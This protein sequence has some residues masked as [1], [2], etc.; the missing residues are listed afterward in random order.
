MT[1]DMVRATEKQVGSTRQ[2][3][4]AVDKVADMARRIFDEM[5]DRRTGS[6]EVIEDL[7]RV[8]KGEA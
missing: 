4:T 6:R 7:Q 2:I 8:Q 1:E 5:E 3:E